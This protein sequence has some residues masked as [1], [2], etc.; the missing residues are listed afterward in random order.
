MVFL[1]AMSLAQSFYPSRI[2]KLP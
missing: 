2:L 1:D